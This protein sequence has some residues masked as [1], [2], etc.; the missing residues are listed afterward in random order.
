MQRHYSKV[1]AAKSAACRAAQRRLD[2]TTMRL[3]GVRA[4][5]RNAQHTG[6][7]AQST[8][9][10]TATRAVDSNL[11]SARRCLDRLRKAGD[12]EWEASREDLDTAFED[13]YRS[14]KRLVAVMEDSTNR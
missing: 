11:D 14:I 4:K 1:L 13:L 9:L 2:E 8:A 12:P 10:E 6:H 7:L 5:I 3:A